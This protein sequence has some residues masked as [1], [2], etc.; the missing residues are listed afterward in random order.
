MKFNNNCKLQNEIYNADELGSQFCDLFVNP[1][2]W[3]KLKLIR[4]VKQIFVIEPIHK[5]VK[6]T[7]TCTSTCKSTF[8]CKSNKVLGISEQARYYHHAI[9]VCFSKIW[10]ELFSSWI[11]VLWRLTA[12]SVDQT[13]FVILNKYSVNKQRDFHCC[14]KIV[15]KINSA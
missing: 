10:I 8:T 4:F 5:L 14:V 6:I 2:I 9:I 7:S 15:A 11:Y 13:F 12:V 3:P 1:S